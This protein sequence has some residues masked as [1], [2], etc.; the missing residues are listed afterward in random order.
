MAHLRK[1]LFTDRRSLC[2]Q[3]EKPTTAKTWLCKIGFRIRVSLEVNITPIPQKT[4]HPA[5]LR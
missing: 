1:K 2:C 4:I 5:K 3:L